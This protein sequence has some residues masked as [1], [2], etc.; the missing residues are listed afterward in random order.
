M[1]L[2]FRYDSLFEWFSRGSQAA[3]PWNDWS[4]WS[5]LHPVPVLFC[6][7]C[8]MFSINTS[9][10]TTCTVPTDAGSFKCRLLAIA[11]AQI[12]VS[13]DHTCSHVHDVIWAVDDNG[14]PV[15]DRDHQRQS[16]IQSAS[17]G[18]SAHEEAVWKWSR[19][20]HHHFEFTPSPLVLPRL[21]QTDY[22]N[23]SLRNVI[24]ES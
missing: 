17:R 13:L 24:L 7:A 4:A 22:T 12:K 6:P 11:D 20:Q 10:D 23:I 3:K 2:T 5:G 16:L 15:T 18:H 1:G 14:Q 9:L 21:R 8:V 19:T